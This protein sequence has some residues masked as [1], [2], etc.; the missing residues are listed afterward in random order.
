MGKVEW[1]GE[2]FDSPYYH[3]LYKHRDDTEAQDFIDHLVDYLRPLPGESFLDIACGK[4]R[5]AIYLNDKGYHVTGI[6][7]SQANIQAAQKFETDTLDFQQMDMRNLQLGHQYDY[8]LNMFTSFGYFDSMEENLIAI[9]SIYNA[10]K[11]KGTFVLDFLNPYV[12]INGL[13]REEVKQIEGIEFHINR[14]YDGE[15]IIK[16]ISFAVDGKD[17]HYY[18]R[19][20][21]IRRVQ[22]LEYFEHVGFKVKDVFGDYKLNAYDPHSSERLIFIVEK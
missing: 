18:E 14:Q 5:H 22:F 21:A 19:V 1:F 11:T 20:M 17:Y 6:D 3:V 13:V 4:G 10:I 7:L 2:W 9:Q 8:A 12:I 15:S 16:D